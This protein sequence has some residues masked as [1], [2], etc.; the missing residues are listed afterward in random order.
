MI[1]IPLSL[2]GVSLRLM[3][4]GL[5]ISLAACRKP[6]EEEVVEQPRA[7]KVW[8][9]HNGGSR[10]VVELPGQ[11]QAVRQTWKAFEVSG[12]I[13]ENP[14]KE[15][16]AFKK[17]DVLA[18]LDPRDFQADR[19]SAF[20]RY[21]TAK[22]TEARLRRLYARNAVSK[23]QYELAQRDLVTAE[24]D[25]QRAE[26]ALA[27]TELVA[28]FDGTVAKVVVDE[29]AHVNK[30][31]NVMLI[32]DMSSMEIE[33]HVPESL[34]AVPMPGETEYERVENAKPLVIPSAMPEQ[35]FPAHLSEASDTAD[36]VTRTYEATLSFRPPPDLIIR[37]GM[38]AK[39][40]ATIPA[41]ERT[42]SQGFPV[43]PSVV[44]ADSGG[45]S[46][47]WRIDR[48]TMTVSAVEVEMGAMLDGSV[49]L[50]KGLASGDLIAA[51]GVH[52]LHEGQRVRIWEEMESQAK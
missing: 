21:Q 23:A 46:L 1:A 15:G 19:D 38:T 31:E 20:A 40:R 14:L 5:V 49:V 24:S 12:R 10:R 3:L 13:I 32:V 8:E 30:K 26:K 6:V 34:L 42:R 45:R 25:F 36:P 52:R 2:R 4:G 11:I 22:V 41:N 39:V 9:V 37:P 7:V 27:D 50:T 51:S 17:G 48:E 43:P 28:D 47:V 16:Q 44:F 18:K 29:F 33:V 35:A